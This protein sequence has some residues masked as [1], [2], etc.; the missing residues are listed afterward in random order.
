MRNIYLDEPAGERGFW[1]RLER[2]G[3]PS[4][5]VWGDRD[6]LVPA[7]FARHVE[8][9]LPQARSHVLADCGHVPQFELPDRTHDLLTGFLDAVA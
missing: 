4:L 5:F 6:R 3:T 2:M 1:V 8:R 7:G 9:V